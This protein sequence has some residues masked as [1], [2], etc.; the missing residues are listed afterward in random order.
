M[1]TVFS[2]SFP[3]VPSASRFARTAVR[4]HFAVVLSRDTMSTLELVVSELVTNAVEHGRGTI[5][6]AIQHDGV[7]VHG[8]VTDEGGGFDYTP[9]TV[10]SR[11]IRG[12]GLLIVDALVSRWGVERGSTQVRFELNL[13][14]SAE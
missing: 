13:V 4:E 5:A 12:R 1:L 8:S 11:E 6:L 10:D 7:D 9:R 3:P 2:Q 14:E